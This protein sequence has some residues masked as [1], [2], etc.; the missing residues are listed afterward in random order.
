MSDLCLQAPLSWAHAYVRLYQ[1][2]CGKV[3]MSFC[4]FTLEYVLQE[5]PQSIVSFLLSPWDSFLGGQARL[6]VVVS[7][8]SPAVLVSSRRQT[9]SW[10]VSAQN[11]NITRDTHIF[12]VISTASPLIALQC[13]EV[14]ECRAQLL[15]PIQWLLYGKMICCSPIHSV[16][17]YS[18]TIDKCV[19]QLPVRICGQLSSSLMCV[20]PHRITCRTA[21][22]NHF[23]PLF[24]RFWK[25][26]GL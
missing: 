24:G 7:D 13:S 11:T 26:Q 2:D 6:S 22:L 14:Q 15:D 21:L 12:S 4:L 8:V 1:L 10:R 3:E 5:T 25:Y 20:H 9:N 18:I 23:I 17:L 19:L 16:Q